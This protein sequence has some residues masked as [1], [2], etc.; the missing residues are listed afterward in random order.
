MFHYVHQ[1]VTNTNTQ[2]DKSEPKQLGWAR[3]NKTMSW[4]MQK[5]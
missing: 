5:Y 3:K 4:K 1:L 2:S